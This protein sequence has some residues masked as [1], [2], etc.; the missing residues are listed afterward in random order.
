MQVNYFFIDFSFLN[1]F[2]N[3][4]KILSRALVLLQ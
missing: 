4:S 3:R 1:S 2:Y